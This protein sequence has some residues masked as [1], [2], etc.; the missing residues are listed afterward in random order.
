LRQKDAFSFFL[1]SR[2]LAKLAI[3]KMFNKFRQRGDNENGQG[4]R[5]Y[6]SGKEKSNVKKKSK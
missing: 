3:V 1:I 6:D 4:N 5:G 2:L